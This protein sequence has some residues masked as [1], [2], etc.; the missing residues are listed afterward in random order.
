MDRYAVTNIEAIEE[1]SDGRIA[2]RPIRSHFGIRSF[3]ISAWI[4]PKAGDQIINEHDEAHADSGQEE[5]YLVQR[6]RARFE[7]DGDT[8]DAPAGTLV[9]PAPEVK[10]AA[11]AEE[12]GTTI[13]A[14]GATPGEAYR[15]PG[16][17]FWA[18]LVPLYQAGEYEEA[19]DRG[20]Q[21]I[22]AH[23][24]YPVLIYNTACCESLAGQTSEAI[25][26]L[27]LAIGDSDRLRS[28]AATDSD[29]DPIREEPAFKE[30]VG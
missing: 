16:F 27:R 25:E 3:G 2:S 17:E 10:R 24:D 11:F 8:V 9:F 22:E 21:L 20:R 4:G 18:P 14:I 26:H 12:A 13:I 23:P 1:V 30:L 15:A 28:L 5:L 7:V 29:L 6:G 19:A